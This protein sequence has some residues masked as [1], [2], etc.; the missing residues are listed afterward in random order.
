MVDELLFIGT[1]KAPAPIY[2]RHALKNVPEFK[3]WSYEYYR[4]YPY[5]A[6]QWYL[7]E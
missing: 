3:T 2:H 5:R 6:A 4:T 7:D 1:V